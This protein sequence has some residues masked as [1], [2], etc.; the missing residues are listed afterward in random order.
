MS[1]VHKLGEATI[2]SLLGFAVTL[3]KPQFQDLFAN[4]WEKSVSNSATVQLIF[5]PWRNS[6]LAQVEG[7]FT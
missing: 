5:V 6:Y 4:F 7:S 3:L 2:P 1:H